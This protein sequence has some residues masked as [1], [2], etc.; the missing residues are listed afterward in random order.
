[1]T[2]PARLSEGLARA[3]WTT[4][5]AAGTVACLLLPASSLTQVVG[6][7]GLL[8]IVG[9]VLLRPL[10][11]GVR[12][13]GRL[14]LAAGAG[15]LAI[16]CLGAV[17]G[18]LYPALG[19]ARPLTATTLRVTWAVLVAAIAVA[20]F[21]RGADP[22]RSLCN[23]V[24]RT[25]VAWLLVLGI[26]PLLALTGSVRLNASG[27]SA[28]AV[29][30]ACVAVILVGAAVAMPHRP[31]MPA[32]ALLLGMAAVSLAWQGALRGGWLAGFDTQHEYYVGKLAA[33]QAVFPLVSY[34]DPYGG[35]L[36]LTVWPTQL[37]A[38]FGI[39]LRTVLVLA[40]GIAL[41]L[42]VVMVY[43]TLR[44][45]C[46]AR[47]A[48]LLCGVFVVG[49]EPLMQELP[50]ITRQCY[51][52]LFFTILVWAVA[53][54]SESV[55][56]RRLVAAAAGLGIAVCH[57][58]S[59][60]LAAAAVVVGC[61]VSYAARE[62]RTERVLT[63]PVTA[64]IAAAAGLWGGLIAHTGSSFSQVLSSIRTDGFQFLSGGGGVLTKWL[65]AAAVSQ[66]VNAHAIRLADVHLRRTTYRWMHVDPAGARL[67]LVNNPAPSAHGVP[68]L[69]HVLS[70]STTLIDELILVAA[71]VAVIACL[72]QWRS[73][74]RLAAI[75]GLALPFL[76]IS[77]FS[78]LSLTVALDFAPSRVRSQ[79]YL[80]FAVVVGAALSEAKLP[81][82]LHW[83]ASAAARS[84]GR[85][86]AVALPVLAVGGS[87]QLWDFLEPNGPLP[88]QLTT[89]GEQ[90]QRLLSPDDLLAAE[91]LTANHPA[92]FP[93]QSDRFGQLALFDFGLNLR[94]RFIDSVDPVIVDD[95]AWLFAYGPNVRLGSARGG[96]N[97]RIGVFVFPRAYYVSTRAI[98]YVSP[99]DVVFGRIPTS[100]SPA[101]PAGG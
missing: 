76:A 9:S 46:G 16:V 43:V 62:P 19:E 57:Y 12:P 93:L 72:W 15:Y 40:P 97:A 31:W 87:S 54:R 51:A 23:G 81:A 100:S 88:F 71:V 2:G 17:V 36:S 49:C 27:S 4:V 5:L 6:A 25:H 67:P 39:N 35:M 20:A 63:L 84:T 101:L 80:L 56:A 61:A 41:G 3:N 91:W 98:L 7:A 32:R 74:P 66:L 82:R 78:R 26:L 29:L 21:L 59:A 44:E 24:R 34:T 94:P 89:A 69:G 77:A 92:A 53:T 64:F 68:L 37:H 45:W 38:L 70:F 50:L 33:A 96:N 1:M 30:V 58:S 73:R 60:Y 90:A 10:Q 75:G 14:A 48:A 47:L 18:S 11:L 99:S 13:A 85:V 79:A 8:G 42:C 83:F 22:L 55:V 95:H 52:L 28:I 86:L 65:R